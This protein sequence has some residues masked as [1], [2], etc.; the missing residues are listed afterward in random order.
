MARAMDTRS[1][2]TRSSSLSRLLTLLLLL[3]LAI[4]A[5]A[6]AIGDGDEAAGGDDAVVTGPPSGSM[7]RTYGVT[8]GGAAGGVISGAA[9][10]AVRGTVGGTADRPASGTD[11][12][13]V[14][15]TGGPVGVLSPFEGSA[16]PYGPGHRGVDLDVRPG[17]SVVAAADGVVAFTGMVAGRP[18]L[19][20]DH[21]D[22]LRTT[23]EPVDA[24][25][26]RGDH[27]AAGQAVGTVTAGH[28]PPPGCLH[29]GARR[30]SHSYVDPLSLVGAGPRPVRLLPLGG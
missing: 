10:D 17:A 2:T 13:Y 14:W 18:V 7:A 5:P 26:A 21:A 1:P 29:W 16:T 9:G 24:T 12:E 3:V 28:C 19:S 11:V 8:I 25:V 22:G 15:P 27:V 20:I 23:Y 6:P 4:A 30:G